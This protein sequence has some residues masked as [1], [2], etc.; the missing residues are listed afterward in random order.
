M[1]IK[2]YIALLLSNIVITFQLQEI[3]QNGPITTL[4]LFRISSD[5][6]TVFYKKKTFFQRNCRA[7]Y[8]YFKMC[9]DID[10]NIVRI[11]DS[12]SWRALVLWKY[13]PPTKKFWTSTPYAHL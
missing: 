6:K 8:R 5:K 2:K 7:V 1:R 9:I 12:T 13:T 3:Y 10:I 11:N 4:F